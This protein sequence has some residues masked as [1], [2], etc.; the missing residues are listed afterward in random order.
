MDPD[1]ALRNIR[2]AVRILAGE[3]GDLDSNLIQTLMDDVAAM[4]EWLCSGGFLPTDWQA[5]RK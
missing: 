1:R 2:I 4:D 5:N 3:D